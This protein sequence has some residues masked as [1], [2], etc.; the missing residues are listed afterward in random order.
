M[1]VGNNCNGFCLVRINI[2]FLPSD[3]NFYKR[4]TNKNKIGYVL[5]YNFYLDKI[6]MIKKLLTFMK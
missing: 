1:F 5:L 2:S 3:I 6:L 4:Q